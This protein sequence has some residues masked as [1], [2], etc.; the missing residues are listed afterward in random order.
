[1]FN[2]IKN[3]VDFEQAEM[4]KQNKSLK[5]GT[6]F[7]SVVWILALVVFIAVDLDKTV[8]WVWLLGIY[9]EYYRIKDGNLATFRARVNSYM[10]SHISKNLTT[11]VE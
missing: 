1:M 3:L 4:E 5:K 8:L 7:W 9:F 6:F 2:E 10:L 11:K